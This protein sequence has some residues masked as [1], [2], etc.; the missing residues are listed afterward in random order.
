M[1]FKPVNNRIL[2]KPVNEEV[3]TASGILLQ[4]KKEKPDIGIVIEGSERYP[5]GCKVLFSKFGFD[6]VLLEGKAHFVV[7]EDCILGYFTA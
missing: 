6:E 2:V 1:N 5:A 3:A 4:E 7:S